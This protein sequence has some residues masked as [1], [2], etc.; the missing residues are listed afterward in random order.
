MSE[1]NCHLRLYWGGLEL[2]CLRVVFLNRDSELTSKL[3]RRPCFQN[4][5]SRW[6]SLGLLLC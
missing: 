1:Q 2:M 6:L 4:P 3:D 5:V